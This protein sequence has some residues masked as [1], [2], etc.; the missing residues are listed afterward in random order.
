M[1]KTD[2]EVRAQVKR[3][4]DLCLQAEACGSESTKYCA[5]DLSVLLSSLISEEQRDMELDEHER[6]AEELV[7]GIS[8]HEH[9][10]KGQPSAKPR[11][12][13]SKNN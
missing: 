13:G 12:L 3:I 1:T 6:W 8:Q 7:H 10:Q 2:D 4:R 5:G 9:T 11:S